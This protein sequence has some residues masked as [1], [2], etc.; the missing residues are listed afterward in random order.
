MERDR[1]ALLARIASEYANGAKEVMGQ[2]LI[3]RN[4]SLSL[5][6]ISL[7]ILAARQNHT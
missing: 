4:S 3:A 6:P 2:H 5:S 7:N 1:G